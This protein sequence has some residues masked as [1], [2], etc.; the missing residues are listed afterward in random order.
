MKEI[1][2]GF[3]ASVQRLLDNPDLYVTPSGHLSG[4]RRRP[5][6]RPVTQLKERL[7]TGECLATQVPLATG[8]LDLWES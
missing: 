3:G 7:A 5:P 4:C 2:P 8:R 1:S 6:R